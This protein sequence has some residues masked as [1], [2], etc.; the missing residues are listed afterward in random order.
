MQLSFLTPVA[1]LVGLA[2]IVPLT[3]VLLRERRLDRLRSLLGLRR[4]ASRSHAGFVLS[5]SAFFVLVSIAAAQPVVVLKDVVMARTDA[6]TFFLFDVSR[7]MLASRSP[8][9]PTRF[10]RA[11]SLGLELRGEIPDV[12]VGV[13]S[14]TDRPLPHIF[15]TSDREVFERVALNAIGI[16][17]PPPARGEHVRATNFETIEALARDN[18]FSAPSARRL[19]VL[20]SDGES[21]P[22][23]REKLVTHLDEAGVGLIFVRLWSPEERIYGNDGRE[24]P[25]YRPDRTSLAAVQSLAAVTSGGRVFE[26]RDVAGILSSAREFLGHGPTVVAA[27]SER[28]EPLAPYIMLA[29]GVPLSFLLLRRQRS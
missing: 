18:Y 2:L 3:A 19:I 5:V 28:T 10:E 22:F 26:E 14:M 7:S 25:A 11:V 29:A 1:S 4:P 21:R 17:R 9:A 8:Q 16:E 15:P 23:D 27:E 20:F 12:L 13:A 6:E 24:E